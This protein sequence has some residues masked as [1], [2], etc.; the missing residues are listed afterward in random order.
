MLIMNPMDE[1]K[2]D[3][4]IT[5]WDFFAKRAG[6]I[7]LQVVYCLCKCMC[8]N[9]T[10]IPIKISKMIK[11]IGYLSQVFAVR[12]ESFYLVNSHLTQ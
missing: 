8:D 4:M 9:I 5:Q 12:K 6:T 10:Q 2:Q 1:V 7:A 3:G 11:I